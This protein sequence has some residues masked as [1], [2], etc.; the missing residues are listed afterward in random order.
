MCLFECRL[1]SNSCSVFYLV[2]RKV[3]ILAK[4]IQQCPTY[5]IFDGLGPLEHNY[6]PRNEWKRDRRATAVILNLALGVVSGPPAFLCSH[7]LL[8]GVFFRRRSSQALLFPEIPLCN[9]GI[10]IIFIS[11]FL[12][13]FHSPVPSPFPSISLVKT[14]YLPYV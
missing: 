8:S 3:N 13:P 10:P 6:V 5:L 4:T 11:F 9:Q 14:Q 7:K 2:E 1:C 12:P